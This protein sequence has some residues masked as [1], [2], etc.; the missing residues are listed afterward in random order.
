FNMRVFAILWTARQPR[1]HEFCHKLASR[2]KGMLTTID[3]KPHIVVRVDE[4]DVVVVKARHIQRSRRVIQARKVDLVLEIEHASEH[5]MRGRIQRL[6]IR[7]VGFL[8]AA[9]SAA[10]VERSRE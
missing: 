6:E 4:N 2:N 3:S 1:R 8:F 10:G 7:T 9:A 5:E